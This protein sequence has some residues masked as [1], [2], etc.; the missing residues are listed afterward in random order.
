VSE[1]YHQAGGAASEIVGYCF[2]HQQ[3][4]EYA[5]KATELSLAFGEINGDSRK[6]VKIG[7]RIRSALEAAGFDVVWTGSIKD[8]LDINGFWWQRRGKSA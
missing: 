1:R 3:D 6:G 2:Y 4:M 8:K 7:E 5:L